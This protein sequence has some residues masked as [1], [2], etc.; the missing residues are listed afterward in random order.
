MRHQIIKNRVKLEL[1]SQKDISLLNSHAVLN[2]ERSL[3]RN[4]HIRNKTESI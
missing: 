3:V 2:Q 1:Q 4:M